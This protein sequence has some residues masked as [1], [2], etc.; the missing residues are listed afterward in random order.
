MVSATKGFF[1]WVGVSMWVRGFF[2]SWGW[3]WGWKRE[4]GELM[5][6]ALIF[7]FF[8]VRSDLHHLNCFFFLLDS[9]FWGESLG[10]KHHLKIFWLRGMVFLD[11]MGQCRLWDERGFRSLKSL[12]LSICVKSSEFGVGVG[13]C[14]WS[15]MGASLG[16]V[17]MRTA[18]TYS[19][20]KRGKRHFFK[21]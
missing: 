21:A 3:G 5:I 18:K 8:S 10:T 14:R 19:R 12:S 6:C 16:F 20:I 7:P 1:L 13:L 11:S 4:K 17:L 2:C 9:T 15:L